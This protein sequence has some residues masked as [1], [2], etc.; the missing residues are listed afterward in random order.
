VVDGDEDA[1]F[2]RPAHI[3]EV[4]LGSNNLAEDLRDEFI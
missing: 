3:E 1:I 2:I 4:L